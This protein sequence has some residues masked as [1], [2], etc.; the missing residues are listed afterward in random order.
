[1]TAIRWTRRALDATLLVALATVALTAAVALA[2]PLTGGRALVIGGGS[3]E[4][5]IPRGALVLAMPVARYEVGDVVAVGQPGATPYT[6]R[7][8]RLA[9]Y[10]GRPHVETRGDANEDPDPA[11]VPAISIIGRVDLALPL[12][13]YL[14]LLLGSVAG[15]VGFVAVG[16][17]LLI[18]SGALEELDD[19]SCAACA[20][21]AA[22]AGTTAMGSPSLAREPAHG[23]VRDH[24]RA[25]DPRLPVLLERDRRDPRR[26]G[27]VTVP[28]PTVD[29]TTELATGE[30]AA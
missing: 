6:H 10:E 14:G 25:R 21:E 12:L 11:L 26:H 7:V 30:L 4:P 5:S 16:G 18:M 19:R 22:G 8:S 24:R 29:P 3:M 2:A 15:L 23:R 13:G 20:A 9:E 17:S 1:M 27:H 28:P